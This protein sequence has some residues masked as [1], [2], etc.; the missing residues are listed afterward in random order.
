M[1]GYRYRPQL[2]VLPYGGTVASAPAVLMW[3]LYRWLFL[4]RLRIQISTWHQKQPLYTTV[5]SLRVIILTSG[6]GMEPLFRLTSDRFAVTVDDFGTWCRYRQCYRMFKQSFSTNQPLTMQSRRSCSSI[7]TRMQNIPGKIFQLKQ[8][9]THAGNLWQQRSQV[10]SK[11]IYHQQPILK[12]WMLISGSC[13][14]WCL[15][16]ST[17]RWKR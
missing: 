11:G 9:G 14:F 3:T 6:T 15:P 8:Y 1:N 12:E 5:S 4:Q 10:Y 7:P 2:P 17:P 16:R 13:W